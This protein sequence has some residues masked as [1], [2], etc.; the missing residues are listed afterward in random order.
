M[1][2]KL[3]LKSESLLLFKLNKLM[4]PIGK[5]PAPGDHKSSLKISLPKLFLVRCPCALIIN[6][7]RVIDFNNA[8]KNMDIF[9][10][11]NIFKTR[12]VAFCFHHICLFVFQNIL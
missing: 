5:K 2:T 11:S 8:F 9:S 4:V 3:F 12:N 10:L 7:E 1:I 6:D